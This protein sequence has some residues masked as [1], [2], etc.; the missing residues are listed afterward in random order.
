[1]AV[2]AGAVPVASATGAEVPFVAFAGSFG[3]VAT[4]VV[5]SFV[6]AASAAIGGV[7]VRH[8]VLLTYLQYAA[9]RLFITQLHAYTNREG[10]AM[11]RYSGVQDVI[12]K[13]PVHALAQCAK[14]AS[15]IA[16]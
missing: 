4:F 10:S 9:Q 11:P 3:V 14:T 7:D 8:V 2:T 6:C 15:Q 13:L 5:A 1:V 16:M 12:T